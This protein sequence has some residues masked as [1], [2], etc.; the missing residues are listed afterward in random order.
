METKAN[1]TSYKVA[2]AVIHPAYITL[3]NR[4]VLPYDICRGVMQPN[5]IC[6]GAR[7]YNSLTIDIVEA[8]KSLQD[9]LDRT[10]IARLNLAGM[11]ACKADFAFNT[12]READPLPSTEAAEY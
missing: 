4:I 1:K 8:T 5:V 12:D 10:V 7:Y 2:H 6:K 11:K 3:N 9:E